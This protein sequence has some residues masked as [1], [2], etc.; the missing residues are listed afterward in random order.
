[1]A[2]KGIKVQHVGLLKVERPWQRWVFVATQSFSPVAVLRLLVVASLAVQ[3]VLQGMQTSIVVA[4]RLYSMGSVVVVHGLSCS[5]AWNLWGQAIE[6][7][8]PALEGKFLTTGP[9]GKPPKWSFIAPLLVLLSRSALNMQ[10]QRPHGYRTNDIY[11]LGLY[12]KCLPAPV[13]EQSQRLFCSIIFIKLLKSILVY[14]I[15]VSSF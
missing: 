3:H 7:M 5:A 6:T 15:F 4:R 13:V 1:M 2:H 14:E 8:A 12:G 10:S 9:P 11:Y